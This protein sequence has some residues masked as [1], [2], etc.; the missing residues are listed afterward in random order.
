MKTSFFII[1]I[2][3][4]SFFAI[5]EVAKT[6]PPKKIYF[7]CHKPDNA[8]EITVSDAFIENLHGNNDPALQFNDATF[9]S[10]RKWPSGITVSGF[11]TKKV[12]SGGNTTILALDNFKFEVGA[13][14]IHPDSGAYSYDITAFKVDDI[15]STCRQR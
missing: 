10:F 11:A 14:K 2:T 1:L 6:E 5:A 7:E 8:I 15:A 9:V 3:A 4:L 13:P 12:L